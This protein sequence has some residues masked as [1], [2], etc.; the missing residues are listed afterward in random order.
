MKKSMRWMAAGVMMIAAA[1]GWTLESS[2][3][4]QE[5]VA[6]G[7]DVVPTLT[8]RGEAILRKPADQF[9]LTI[10]VVTD[11]RESKDALEKNSEKMKAVVDALREQGLEEKNIKTGRFNIQPQYAPPPKNV[12]GDWRPQITGYTVSN[13]LSIRTTD[14]EKAG[15]II[16][17][18]TEAGANQIESISFDLADPRKH[19]AE[20]IASATQNA[21]TDAN[22]TAAAAGVKLKRILTINVDH[23]WAPQP[24]VRNV[25]AMRGKT[26]DAM[27]MAPPIS[28]GEL[29]V[30]ASVTLVWEIGT[31]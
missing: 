27:E 8:I 16:A 4:A 3:A 28:A 12:S 14:L 29:D 24:I 10:G 25:A 11:A 22:A 7:K 17:A 13:M 9:N 6:G 19:R 26:M 21:I 5:V 1:A 18:V 23:A 20:A 30:N 15:D 2:A 31:D